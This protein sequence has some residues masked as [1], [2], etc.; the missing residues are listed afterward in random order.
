MSRIVVPP[1]RFVFQ[2]YKCMQAA[3]HLA[4]QTLYLYKGKVSQNERSDHVCEAQHSP[5]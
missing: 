3:S 1:Q 5:R 2:H 4:A